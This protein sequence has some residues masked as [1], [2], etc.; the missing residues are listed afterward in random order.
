M[1]VG[2]IASAA[3]LAVGVAT[4]NPLLIAGGVAGMVMTVDSAMGMA[5]DGKVCISGGITA[6]C[7]ACGMDEEAAKW[8]GMG[9]SMALNI[10]TI[11]F[12][13]GGAARMGAVTADMASKAMQALA[14]TSMITN[15]VNGVNGVAKGATTIASGVYSYQISQSKADYKVLEAIL[16]RIRTSIDFDRDMVEAEMQ[17][18]ND[19]LAAVNEIV[20]SCNTTQTSVLTMNPTMA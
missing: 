8:V 10:A 17:R 12:N 4:A 15:L 16:E 3:T 18:A 6:A 19:L 14:R 2:A 5:T 7:T 11:V 1:I 20:E 13:V 9:V